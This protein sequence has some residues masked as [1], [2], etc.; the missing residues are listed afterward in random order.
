MSRWTSS[1]IPDQTG[2]IA[3]I[4]GGNTGLGLA[5][6]TALAQHGASVVLAGRDTAKAERAAQQIGGGTSYVRLDLALLASVRDAAAELR[7]RLTRIDLLVNNAG[8]LMT[9]EF[10]T[11]D[12]FELHYGTNHLGHFALTGLLL[13][14]MTTVPGS[15]VVT[16]TSPL[17]ARGQYP[18]RDQFTPSGAYSDAKLANLLFALELQRRLAAAHA[19]TISLAAHPGYASTGLLRHQPALTRLGSRLAVPLI[20][21]SAAS[22]ALPILRAAT[23]PGAHGGQFYRPRW[24]TRGHPVPATPRPAARDA[25]AARQLWAESEENTHVSYN[26]TP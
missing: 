18:P 12:G 2:R 10:T 7:S 26:L 19:D 3:V 1:D 20:G 13:D 22:G 21:Q 5:A 9:R 25:Q 4:T 24:Q 15:R 11:G 6:A 23:D 16:V 14:L 8:V 17:Y